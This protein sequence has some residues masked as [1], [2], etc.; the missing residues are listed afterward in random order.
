MEIH[1]HANG[2]QLGPFPPA[3]VI[4]M[5]RTGAIPADAS[6]WHPD[7]PQWYPLSDFLAEQSARSTPAY[8]PVLPLSPSVPASDEPSANTYVLRGVGAGF[9]TALI[10]GGLWIAVS[11]AAG[12][13]IPYVGL[14]I[15]WLVG[16]A[17]SKASREEAAPIL[18][19]SAVVFTLLAHGFFIPYFLLNPW[20]WLSLAF[21][22]YNAWK[23]SAN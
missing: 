17:T 8:S 5:A 13:R 7:A 14:L 16:V 23:A 1:V 2:Q 21:A 18:P 15:G 22:C 10:G 6:V 9:A 20:F 12:I 19:I 11:L 4:E 3:E